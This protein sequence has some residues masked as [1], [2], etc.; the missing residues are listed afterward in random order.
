MSHADLQQELSFTA[1]SQV[2]AQS[3]DSHGQQDLRERSPARLR[4]NPNTE[5][6]SKRVGTRGDK[7]HWHCSMHLF[8]RFSGHDALRCFAWRRMYLYH[9]CT[10]Q[11]PTTS[12]LCWVQS[13]TSPLSRSTAW[14]F[15]RRSTRINCSDTEELTTLSASLLTSYSPGAKTE[16]PELDA[17]AL[18]QTRRWDK[19]SSNQQS[20]RLLPTGLWQDIHHSKKHLA[21]VPKGCLWY[22][23]STRLAVVLYFFPCVFI[24]QNSNIHHDWNQMI[25]NCG[26]MILSAFCPASFWSDLTAVFSAVTSLRMAECS[27]IL[28][29]PRAALQR[30]FDKSSA[31]HHLKQWLDLWLWLF[32]HWYTAAKCV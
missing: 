6:R 27:A 26:E 7:T 17:S 22:L 32:S 9:T 19:I 2:L 10:L 23:I 24:Q 29:A 1:D 11:P 30:V 28:S 20:Q 4:R 25:Y 16:V 15:S 8:L 13:Q 3:Y 18:P 31:F 5:R 12:P 14:M 21:N